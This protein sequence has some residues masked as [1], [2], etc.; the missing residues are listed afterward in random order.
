MKR[1]ITLPLLGLLGAAAFAGPPQLAAAAPASLYADVSLSGTLLSGSG[2]VSATRL[3]PGRYEVAFS[4]D[5]SS[6]AYVATTTN[7]YSQALGVFTAGGHS[8]VDDVYVETKN[9]GGGLTDGPFDLAVVCGGAGLQYA[10]VGY[11]EQL[12]R[13]SPS[14]TL[15]HVGTGRYRVHFPASVSHCAYLASVGDPGNAIAL[16]P[17]GV[18]TGSGT[19]ARM[20]YV[21][22]KN[23]GGGLTDGIP[24][25]LAVVC[26]P[27][28]GT[29]VAVV[30]ADG[31]IQRGSALT[32]S[33]HASTGDYVFVTNRSLA[34]CAVIATR[35]SVDRSV[36]FDPATVE[37]TPG[38]AA[39]TMGIQVRSLLFFGGNLADEAF[40]AAAF[41]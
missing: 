13:A 27:A 32:S 33:F 36:P 2:A 28:A 9:Q 20:V 11:S 40:H 21:E 39:N 23:P 5:V 30:G 18:Y 29:S 35:G 37:L 16:A 41:C 3:G 24:F 15:T 6:C 14:T 8:S 34:S 17:A 10:V 22:T 1:T 4:A 12:V 7:A 26:P 25:H 38:P 19:N 31:L